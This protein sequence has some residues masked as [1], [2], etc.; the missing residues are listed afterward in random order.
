[1]SSSGTRASVCAFVAPGGQEGSGGWIASRP[2][3][4]GAGDEERNGAHARRGGSWMN[5]AARGPA[6][7]SF[8]TRPVPIGGQ[9]KRGKPGAVSPGQSPVC[10]SRYGTMDNGNILW[11]YDEYESPRRQPIP[12][13][14][15]PAHRRQG[16]DHHGAGHGAEFAPGR[17]RDS[18]RAVGVLGALAV[19]GGTAVVVSDYAAAAEKRR[20]ERTRGRG[21]GGGRPEVN[22]MVA[23][24][25]APSLDLGDYRALEQKRVSAGLSKSNVGDRPVVSEVS[26][27][28]PKTTNIRL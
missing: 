23:E 24:M 20:C 12:R 21:R 18:G 6:H 5:C 3:G 2:V 26:I 9:R 22:E 17:H 7:R 16:V 15:Q 27:E 19:G 13:H 8:A 10:A 4:A 11:Q 1:M 14:P 25:A 28:I